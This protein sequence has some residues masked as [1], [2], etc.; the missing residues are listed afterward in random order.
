MGA[1]LQ[2]DDGLRRRNAAK[3]D[4]SYPPSPADTDDGTRT[5]ST[6]SEQADGDSV[7]LLSVGPDDT[8]SKSKSNGKPRGAFT[9]AR[10]R[11]KRMQSPL[12]DSLEEMRQNISKGVEIK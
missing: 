7:S 3:D 6:E 5:P 12:M 10:R 11:M 2:P 4:P 8:G 9:E 1:S